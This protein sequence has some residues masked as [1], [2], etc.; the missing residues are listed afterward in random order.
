ME[1]ENYK[2]DPPEFYKKLGSQ[3]EICFLTGRHLSPDSARAEHIKPLRL[4][5]KHDFQNIC[6]VLGPLSKLKRYHT[7]K[8]IVEIAFDIVK[9]KGEKY[10]FSARRKTT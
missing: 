2:F 7:E 10:G 3:N 9:F 4:G 5:G 6:I 8:E 1:T